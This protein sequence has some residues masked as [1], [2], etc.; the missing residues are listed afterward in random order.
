MDLLQFLLI[1]KAI[2]VDKSLLPRLKGSL[3]QH[4][5]EE[6][7]GGRYDHLQTFPKTK[8]VQGYRNGLRKVKRNTN[9]D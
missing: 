7:V 2:K 3:N 8:N 1:S 5:Q 4:I 9:S 6:G